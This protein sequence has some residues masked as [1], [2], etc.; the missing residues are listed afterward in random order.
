MDLSRLSNNRVRTIVII[1][2]VIVSIIVV[3]LYFSS[4]SETKKETVKP[5][6]TTTTLPEKNAQA[7]EFLT[8]QVLAAGNIVPDVEPK[9]TDNRKR[10]T[11]E[12]I[13]GEVN[14]I[15]LYVDNVAQCDTLF[16][17]A[18]SKV[19]VPEVS[20]SAIYTDKTDPTIIVSLGERC[21]FLQGSKALVSK[22]QLT[23]IAKAVTE[24]F[25]AVD[26][27]TTTTTIATLVL[28]EATVGTPGVNTAPSTTVPPS[29]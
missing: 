18:T 20:P 1:A 5:T 13:G 8:E 10:C 26:S 4:G 3:I 9:T 25:V 21:F 29:S 11:F 6:T 28:P 15:T 16:A 7:C 27:S 2:G 17:D 14:Y 23:A 12:D 24:L 22:A 19:A